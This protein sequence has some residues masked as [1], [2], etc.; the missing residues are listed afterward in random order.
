[1]KIAVCDDH[2]DARSS[3][4]TDLLSLQ[5]RD[6]EFE[7]FEF[8]SG[9]SLLANFTDSA[10]DMIVLDIEMGDIDGLETAGRVRE[11]DKNVIIIFLTNYDN[12]VY[13]GYEVRAFRYILKEQPKQLCMKQLQDAIG[14]YYHKH[15]FIVIDDKQ[16]KQ[17]IFISEIICV[18]V[19]LREISIHTKNGSYSV[20]GKL[21]DYE[22]LLPESLFVKINKSQII[23]V[24]NVD[25][26]CKNSIT[27]KN[28]QTLIVSR[29]HVQTVNAM[30]INYIKSRC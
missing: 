9:E 1:M 24:Q 13:K 30:F 17:K 5:L 25:S 27:L 10:F 4:K 3:V 22:S 18:E 20:V 14:E 21:K 19:F 28:G 23:N 26:I 8:E 11:I 15:K 16:I 12:F 6:D 7:I 29:N 2:S